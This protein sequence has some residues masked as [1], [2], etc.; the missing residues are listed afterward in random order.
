M[1]VET[2]VSKAAPELTFRQRLTWVA[3]LY[4]AVAYQ[5]HGN[6]A[7][8]LVPFIPHDGVVVD[9]GAHSGQYMK[10]FARLASAG[11]VYAFEPGVYALSI[12]RRVVRYRGLGNVT[13]LPVGMSDKI[14]T[15]T[16]YVPI[17]QSGSLGFGLSH[18]GESDDGR[19]TASETIHLTTLDH[20]VKERGLTRVDFVKVDIEGWEMHFLRGAL[21]TIAEL[22]PAVLMEVIEQMLTRV[23]ASPDDIFDLFAA[24]NYV[25]FESPEYG[26]QKLRRIEH[27]RQ[28]MDILFV[29]AE[30]AAQFEKE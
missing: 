8:R 28:A 23:G 30:K 9:V 25:A 13:I 22:R 3:H 2:V 21:K 24:H 12:L 7:T 27:F 1:S 5:Y 14:T 20:F 15:E 29:P 16:L 26:G 10:I 19:A 18:I 17:K 4:K 6:L 11:H